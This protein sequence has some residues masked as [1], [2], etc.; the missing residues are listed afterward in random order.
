VRPQ[1][2]RYVSQA[3]RIPRLLPQTTVEEKGQHLILSIGSKKTDVSTKVQYPGLS[4]TPISWA[5][6]IVALAPTLQCVQSKT[7][8]TIR[9]TQ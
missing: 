6:S 7:V 4:A 9:V 3:G 5:S 2:Q 8:G 1:N